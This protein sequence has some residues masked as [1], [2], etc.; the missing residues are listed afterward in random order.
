MGR[1]F[2]FWL[3]FLSFFASVYAAEIDLFAQ[4]DRQQLR[5]GERL[6]YA[7]TLVGVIRGT[8]RLELN[9]FKGFSVIS[10]GQS[11]Q[12]R[13]RN[14][15]MEQALTLTYTLSPSAPGVYLLGPARV[16]YEGE[17]YATEAIEIQVVEEGQRATP[18]SLES[19]PPARGNPRKA[20]ALR[21]GVVL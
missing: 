16:E 14:G 21:G 15:R 11:Q 4:V 10:T 19:H 7:V 18:S 13:N 12:F 6:T 20:P 8:P 5:P 3:V 1:K 17:I 9:E 2:L